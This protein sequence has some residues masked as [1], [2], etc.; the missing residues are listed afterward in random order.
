[1]KVTD[2]WTSA[3]SP[4]LSFELFPPRSPKAAEKL[5]TTIDELTALEPDFVS[6]TFGAGGST[7]QGSHQLIEKL[8]KEKGREVIAY[9]AGYGL[10][11]EDILAVLDSYQ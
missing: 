4:T 1:M 5:E 10:G 2:I 11:P 8:R 6:V 3:K 9:F 7:R